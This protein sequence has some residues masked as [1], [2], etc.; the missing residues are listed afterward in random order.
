MR[1]GARLQIVTDH[2]GYFEQIETVLRSSSLQLV[3]FDAP[4]AAESAEM[5]GSNFERKYRREGRPFH[6]VAAQRV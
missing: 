1:R 4:A 5:V 3:D 6:V 2:A